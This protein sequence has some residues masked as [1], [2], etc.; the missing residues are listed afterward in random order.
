MQRIRTIDTFYY[1][2]G[3]PQVYLRASYDHGKTVG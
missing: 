2:W 3:N 1:D